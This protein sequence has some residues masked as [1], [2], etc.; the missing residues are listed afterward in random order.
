MSCA[1]GSLCAYRSMFYILIVVEVSVA[2]SVCLE[3]INNALCGMNT[4]PYIFILI[5]AFVV[6]LII[7]TA[8][9]EPH[10]L[11][12]FDSVK[13]CVSLSGCFVHPS[14]TSAVCGC[15]EY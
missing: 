5:C 2:A 3:V 9:L 7:F 14:E 6:W 10:V 11:L 4:V 13:N 15:V 1:N 8:C 12:S